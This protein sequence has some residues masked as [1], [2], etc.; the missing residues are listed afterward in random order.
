MVLL[1]VL[2]YGVV[3][4]FLAAVVARALRIVRTPVHLRW[5]LYPV[6]HEKGKAAHGGS[7]LEEKDWWLTKHEVDHWGEL[8]VMLAEILLL[9]GVWEHNR[10][11]WVASFPLHFG[12]YLLIGNGALLLAAGALMRFG[13]VLNPAAGFGAMLFAFCTLLAWVGALL[14]AFGALLMLA[15][16]IL[17]PDM[18]RWS[19]PGHYFNALLLGAIDI[20]L[21]LWLASDG[22]VIPRLA[23]FYSGILGASNLPFLP[24]AGLWHLGFVLLFLLVLPFTHMTHFFIK[25]FT[26]HNVRWEDAP[27]LP[28]GKLSREI[29]LAVAQ[30]V[31]WAAPHVR[32]EG[33]KNWVDVAHDVKA[34]DRD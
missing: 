13:V 2:V 11:L 14:G 21:L 29:G 24:A 6:P 30:T 33:K 12:L 28:G 20:S 16:R 27:N 8:R 19:N 17:E 26:Y 18:R 34:E 1:H 5:E 23:M 22:G 7:V 10:S 4:I 25:Y 9:K 32:S 31:S 15:K 3:L